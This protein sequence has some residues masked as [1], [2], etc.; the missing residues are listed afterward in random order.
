M[1]TPLVLTNDGVVHIQSF[2]PEYT[3]CGDAM[4]GFYDDGCEEG[5]EGCVAPSVEF[6]VNTGRSGIVRDGL[7]NFKPTRVTCYKCVDIVNYYKSLRF[8]IG[9][10]NE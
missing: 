5:G 8:K 2:H 10:E 1:K 3:V 9:V 7:L 6:L 4:E